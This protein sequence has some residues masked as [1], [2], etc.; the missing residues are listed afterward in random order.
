MISR[1]GAINYLGG[2][3]FLGDLSFAGVL[4]TQR[5][6]MPQIGIWQLRDRRIPIYDICSLRG[7]KISNPSVSLPCLADSFADEPLQKLGFNARVQSS[8]TWSP[9]GLQECAHN[10]LS[11][12]T[13][14]FFSW[15]RQ[16][17]ANT[18]KMQRRCDSV[19]RYKSWQRGDHIWRRMT[20]T[21]QD[22]AVST[23]V[24]YSAAQFG[25]G[26]QSQSKT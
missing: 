22:G 6:G 17:M 26:Q 18:Q 7:I 2:F 20:S 23:L 11:S 4:L 1:R 14:S 12:T 19:Q 21:M 15:N 16:T 13:T 3:Y 9:L 24:W 10:W 25:V 8:N 5:R